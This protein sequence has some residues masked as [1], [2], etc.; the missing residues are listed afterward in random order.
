MGKINKRIDEIDFIKGIFILLMVFFHFNF[1]TNKHEG[2]TTWIYCFHMSGFLFLS[3]YLQRKNNIVNAIRKIFIP[4]ILVESVYLIGLNTLGSI[5]GS[6]NKVSLNIFSFCDYLL[7]SPIGTYWYLHTLFLCI[8][9][10]YFI[11]LLKIHDYIKLL[12]SGSILFI[13]TFYID[14]LKWE[15]IIYFLMGSFIQRLN[16]RINEFII[17][18]L[19][20]IIPI[21]LISL[22]SN[23][24]QRGNLSGVGL[25]F[26]MISFL[27]NISNYIPN[28]SKK[29]LCF[30]GRNSFCIVLF[31]PIYTILT[32]QYISLFNFDSTHL[33]WAIVSLVIVSVLC[34]LTAWISDTLKISQY[35][36]GGK[37]YSR[38]E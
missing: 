24:L 30:F 6:N 33:L 4:Y 2:L 16:F 38:Y 26:F 35:I 15:N 17:P 20:S 19:W 36:A 32:K 12:I 29:I 31:S 5:L 18:S 11:S 10:N 21:I 25:T 7:I 23:N 22:F 28:H 9:V 27:W 14:G 8:I 13:L 3:G 37:I 1:F 34:L